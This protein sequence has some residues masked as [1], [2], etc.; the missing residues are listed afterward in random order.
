MAFCLA[1]KRLIIRGKHSKKILLFVPVAL[2]GVLI[3]MQLSTNSIMHEIRA[4]FYCPDFYVE[5]SVYRPDMY[6]ELYADPNVN[7]IVYEKDP[8]RPNLYAHFNIT[9]HST[10]TKHLEDVNIDLRL[11]RLFEWHNFNRGTVWIMYSVY[12]SDKDGN[13]IFGSKDIP[14]RLS[15]R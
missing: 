6:P 2:I 4:A 5:E 11:S 9:H 14:V 1:W 8:G 7:Y 3:L 15:I 12:V 10:A 13:H